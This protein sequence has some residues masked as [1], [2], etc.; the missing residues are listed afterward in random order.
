MK[1]FLVVLCTCSSMARVAS[2]QGPATVGL[3]ADSGQSTGLLLRW[4]VTGNSGYFAPAKAVDFGV[5]A[6]LGVQM[7]ELLGLYLNVGY[8]SGIGL[9]GAVSQ[10]GAAISIS[11]VGITYLA[12]MAELDLGHFFVAGGPML[13]NGGW[14]Q[15]AEGADSSGNA[16]QYAVAAGGW[17]PGVEARLG[18]VF[19]DPTP[20]PHNGFA[21]ARGG[22]TL[23]LD[24]KVL[25]ASVTS[26]SQQAGQG[27]ASQS[28]NV[29][30][31][32]L[33][34]T[35]MLVLGYDAVR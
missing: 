4:G 32:V 6:R 17:M 34:V 15:V 27:S 33:G 9:G 25:S 31:H 10:N 1:T 35:P 29:G 30:D 24:L 5:D 21:V 18:F 20:T 19:G 22:F 3:D 26:A 7:N 2:A 28:I 14:G 12:P 16:Y 11:G 23:A 13:A 8:V